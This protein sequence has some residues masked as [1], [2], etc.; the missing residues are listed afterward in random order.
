M[1]CYPYC[2]ELLLPA[3]ESGA[4]SA[5]NAPRA[6]LRRILPIFPLR[7]L[8][9]TL[10]RRNGVSF[11]ARNGKL[12]PPAQENAPKSARNAPRHPSAR[13]KAVKLARK[14][15]TPSSAQE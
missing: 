10:L 12:L 5:R 6:V 14:C 9:G 7:L 1:Y 11:P 3:R 8:R 15:L 4:F 13:E 2:G